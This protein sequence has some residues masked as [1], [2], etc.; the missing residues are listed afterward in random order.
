MPEDLAPE[1][2]E[3]APSPQNGDIAPET[4]ET[5]ET[6]AADPAEPV[7]ELTE[8]QKNAKVL[9]EREERSRKSANRIQQRFNE[10]ADSI[11]RQEA[12]AEAAERRND[13]LIAAM[14]GRQQQGPQG[15]GEPKR[16]DP[17]FGGDYEKYLD[18]RTEWRADQRFAQRMQEQSQ[19]W[20][21]TS[22]QH[23]EQQAAA[24]FEAQYTQK[25]AAGIKANPEH[26]EVIRD[27]DDVFVGNAIP[28]IAESENPI[29]LMHY[30][31]RNRDA[32]ARVAHL[33][34][35][36][37][38]REVGK[39]ELSLKAKPQV[40]TAPA[41]GQPVGAKPGSSSTPPE[42]PDAYM[43]WAAKHMR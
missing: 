2:P 9:Q 43:A 7:A 8:E 35:I 11:R 10:Q 24:A 18:A 40:S 4:P 13:A 26:L 22:Q 27:N 1:T 14:L 19:Q 30:F 23:N 20:Q 12:R 37:A 25:I 16:D 6:V 38:A 3:I 34:P 21:Q 39:I 17:Q 41:P 31:A 28:A 33:S 15:T 36:A 32:A 42:D 29:A 5:P